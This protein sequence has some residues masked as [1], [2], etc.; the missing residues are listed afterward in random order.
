MRSI[1]VFLLLCCLFTSVKAFGASTD[2]ILTVLDHEVENSKIYIARHERLIDKERKL[3][4]AS[5]NYK[6]RFNHAWN[7]FKL[8]EKF[9]NDSA[10][11]FLDR[12][13]LAAIDMKS[14]MLANRCLIK[15]AHQCKNS[16]LY[17]EAIN[18]LRAVNRQYLA[19]ED[20][21]E[22]YQEYYNIYRING[23]LSK[24]VRF[25]QLYTQKSLAY[26]D[27]IMIAADHHSYI[28][29][30]YMQIMCKDRGEYGKALK[31]N[32]MLMQEYP[33][34][35][36]QYAY[37]AYYRSEIYN[38]MN[39]KGQRKYWLAESCI[40]DVRHALMINAAFTALAN[41]L[42][43]ENDLE[44]AH[45]YIDYSWMCMSRYNTT[46]WYRNAAPVMKNIQL[47]YEKRIKDD[48]K[49]LI[50]VLGLLGAIFIALMLVLADDKRKRR[51]LQRL[52]GLYELSNRQLKDA[53]H[54]KDEYI[55]HYL[56]ACSTDIDK[57]EK[58]RI[59]I[60]RKIR[61]GLYDDIFQLTNSTKLKEKELK[62]LYADFDNTF[63]K[64]F[65]DFIEKVNELLLPEKRIKT[66]RD[67]ELTPALR[68]LALIR[69]GID[70]SADIAAFLRYTPNTIYTYRTRIKN[71]A[72]GN[73]EELEDKVKQIEASGRA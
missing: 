70:D 23:N 63:L 12:A 39:D 59:E 54:V 13:R 14:P 67:K 34:N 10:I 56:K 3:Y 15:M 65:P 22:Y 52:N 9:Q 48:N 28:Y 36:V 32:S 5:A 62:E 26:L 55:G 11:A 68:I 53:N 60:N 38:S 7:L 1:A 35:S 66:T 40:Y 37:L 73:R 6:Q 47:K 25:K 57:M 45:K 49:I 69:L 21:A 64:L 8:Y 18:N 24:S 4:A 50:I 61:A 16:A 58:L 71:M 44:R 42:I 17:I 27:S 72:L 33:Q 31:F 46:I 19:K 51:S 2:S 43:G 41:I 30:N 20:L 29:L